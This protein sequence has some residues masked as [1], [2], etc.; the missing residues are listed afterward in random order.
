M[1]AAWGSLVHRQRWL[2]VAT[3]L[4]IALLGGAWGSGVFDRLSQ[5]G[6]DDPTSEAVQ[7]TKA[8][9]STLGKPGGDFVAIYTVPQGS[10]VDDPNLG[11]RINSRLS[12]LPK[13]KVSKVVSYWQLPNPQFATPDKRRGVAVFTLAG[14]NDDEKLAA[15]DE[16]RGMIAVDGA[17]STVTG[18]YALGKEINETSHNDLV[19]AELISLP[20][21]LVLLVLFFGGLVAASLPVAIGGL[22]ILGALGVLR[23]LTVF[24]DVNTFAVNVATLLGLGLA[25]DYGLFMVGRFREELAG[26]R[27]TEDAVQRTVATAGRTVAFSSTLLV[28]ALGGLLLFPQAFLKSVGYGGMAAVGIAA[29]LSLTL[30]PAVFAVLG[31]RVDAL[32]MPWRRGKGAVQHREWPGWRKLA[33]WVMKRPVFVAAPILAM[34]FVLGAPFL[35]VNFGAVT[36]KVLP[37]ENSARQSAEQLMREFPQLGADGAQIVLRGYQGKAPTPETV[38]K[39]IGEVA[40]VPGVTE[41]KPG[42]AAGD[43]ATIS[44]KLPGGSLSSEAKTAVA[45]LRN[46]SEPPNTEVM[47]GGRTAEVVDSLAATAAQLP[48]M[49]ALVVGA[50]MVLMF[51]AFG[52]VMM[53]IKAVVMSAVSLTATFGALVWVF[54]DGHGADLL[55]VEPGPLEAGVV[56]LMAAVVFGLSTDYEVFLMSRMVEARERGA[57]TEEAVSIGLGKTGKVISAAAVLLIVVTG[58]FSFSDMALMRFI[59]IGMILA[60]ALDATI[61]RM[62]LVPALVKLQGEFTWWAPASLRRLQQRIGLQ[63]RDELDDLVPAAAKALE[64]TSSTTRIPRFAERAIAVASVVLEPELIQTV[65]AAKRDFLHRLEPLRPELFQYCLRLAGD[66]NHAERLVQET[67]ARAFVACTETAN[68]GIDRPLPWLMR[69][70]TKTHVD[71]WLKRV[72]PATGR[73]VMHRTTAQLIG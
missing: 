40:K 54:Q 34:L 39:F 60:L 49:I 33:D 72:P 58:A 26:G 70:A 43:V 59:G 41:V 31:R 2:V 19:R 53:P 44:A 15:F 35:G 23:L 25:I 56:V 28:I 13:D 38:Q 21:T 64:T 8:V 6:Y 18:Y 57:T 17:Q 71:S 29:V 66:I 10:T 14:A 12:T 37:Q 11:Q 4:L 51:L 1:F 7:A 73:L 67:M 45:D 27:S 61:V 22:T 3:V 50:T 47:V 63:E 52:S 5:G 62:L 20:V 32:S 55:G 30:L 68:P 42:Q 16:V 69:I 65:R 24:S 46:L 36:E 48:W 9:E